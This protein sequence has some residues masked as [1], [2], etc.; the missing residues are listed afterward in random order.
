MNEKLRFAHLADLHLGS[1][2]EKSLRELN[3]LSF[4][5]AIDKIL[6]EKLDF[7]IFAGDIFNN[8]MP[9]IDLVEKVVDELNKLKKAGIEIYVIG[10]SHDYSNLGKS[11]IS[12]L[13]KTGVLVDV[14]KFEYLSKNEIK[15][16]YTK[17]D[18]LKLNIVGVLGKKHGLDKN[19]Y[20][21]ISGGDLSEN[22]FNV[23]VF[24][25]TLDNFKPNFMKAVK[26]EIT[27]EYLPKGFDYYAGGHIHTFMQSE[28]SGSPISYSGCLFPNN[29]SELKREKP[30]FSICEFD[31]NTRSVDI[32][33]VYLNIFNK[34]YLKVEIDK[35]NP[36]EAYNLIMDKL[37]SL[38]IEGKVFLLELVGIIDGKVSD[39]GINKI[40]GY[41][42]SQGARVVLKNS[43]KLSSL[44]LED[45]KVSV[46]KSTL[47]IENFFIDE[48]LNEFEN[49]GEI[50]S[51][52]KEI[53]SILFNGDFSKYEGE[54]TAEFN[55]RIVD[56]MDRILL[57][58]REKEGFDKVDN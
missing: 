18:K 28:Y 44:I 24:H 20:K 11:F 19:I 3:F 53:I 48:V 43:Y 40:M 31:F 15:L 2:R 37:D 1:F 52:Y 25:T 6:S 22:Y 5:K 9:P 8:A 50:L 27:K 29:F 58:R 57:E 34:E 55:Q 41:I 46:D 17:N 36:V 32:K 12:L 35:L 33:R 49:N 13:D 51:K 14:G 10:G 7:V 38:N 54:K 30:G 23:F 26:T 45:K 56:F 47:D 42:Y 21:N 16:D 39:I 4:K